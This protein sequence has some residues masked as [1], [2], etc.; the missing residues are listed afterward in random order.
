MNLK[1]LLH[2][3]HKTNLLAQIRRRR[4]YTKLEQNVYKYPK[5]LQRAFEQCQPNSFWAT[6]ITYIPTP[7]G[8]LY[9]CAVMDLC[10][11]MV[12]AYRIG[13]DMAASLVTKRSE[14]P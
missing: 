14:T 5:L 4:K 6:G 13:S 3:M 10:G 2:I 9:M 8:M 7:Q 12:L 11:R 1:A